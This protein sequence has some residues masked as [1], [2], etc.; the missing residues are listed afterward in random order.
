MSD[1]ESILSC[2]IFLNLGSLADSTAEVVQLRT[3]NLT[4]TDYVY[5]NNVGRMKGE[6]LFNATAVSDTSD[7]EG[8]GNAALVLCD[9]GALVHLNSFSCTL[10][11][12]V[13]NA[14][15]ITNV[16]LGYV[17][18]ELLI[19]KSLNKIHF[20]ALL[21]IRMFMRAKQRTTLVLCVFTRGNNYITF[22]FP[23][24]EKTKNNY[25]FFVNSSLLTII[26]YY[27]PFYL[28]PMRAPDGMQYIRRGS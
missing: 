28:S 8:R 3:T 16:E 24:Q 1:K 13:V 27:F 12:L 20:K 7:G 21:K 23:L 9:N 14:N 10:N 6:R 26:R 2:E 22:D 11:D 25:E 19:C 18:L 4:L 15:G 5:R 17:F